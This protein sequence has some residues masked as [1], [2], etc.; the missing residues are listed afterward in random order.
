MIRSFRS[1][2]LKRF[3]QTGDGSRLGVQKP[4][5]IRRIFALLD[6]AKAPLQMDVAGFRFRALKGRDR[7]RFAVWV[8]EN[9]RI[10]FGWTG[11][12]AVEIDLEDYH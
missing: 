6:A 7:G 5:R 10:T 8:S 2:A 9:Y 11:E 12:D 1:K 3:A 4:D